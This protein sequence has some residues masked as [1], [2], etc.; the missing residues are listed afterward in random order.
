[1]VAGCQT[2]QETSLCHQSTTLFLLSPLLWTQC[3]RSHQESRRHSQFVRASVESTR[4]MVEVPCRTRTKISYVSPTLS[5][6]EIQAAPGLGK[7]WWHGGLV[8]SPGR[9]P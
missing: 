5:L 9:E 2:G 3:S 4:V 1:M 6:S 8:W 7:V